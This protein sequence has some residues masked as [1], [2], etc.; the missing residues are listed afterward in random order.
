MRAETFASVE[1]TVQRYFDRMYDC[2][3]DRFDEG[4][5][6]TARLRGVMGGALI[7]WPAATHRGILAQRRSPKASQADRQEEILLLDAV[8]DD[9]ALAKVRARIDVKVFVDHLCLLQADSHWRATS[10]TFHLKQES[11]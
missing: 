11:V 6:P 2:N 5:H 7:V 10:K 1:P 8:G 4:S 9:P 3:I